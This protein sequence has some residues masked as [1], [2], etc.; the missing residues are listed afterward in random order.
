MTVDRSEV[1]IVNSDLH[2][3]S[4]RV[5]ALAAALVRSPTDNTYCGHWVK[6]PRFLRKVWILRA[7]ALIGCEYDLSSQISIDR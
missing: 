7:L 2:F 4:S 1:L 5:Q 3:G 6:Y